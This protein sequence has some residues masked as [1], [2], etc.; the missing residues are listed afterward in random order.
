M[1]VPVPIDRE[2]LLARCLDDVEFT[3]QMLQ[4]FQDQSPATL[5]RLCESVNAGAWE[6]AKRHAHTLKGTAGNLSAAALQAAAAR[7]EKLV[8]AGQSADLDAAVLDLTNQFNL[9]LQSAIAISASMKYQ[10]R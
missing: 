4:I 5:T 8:E 3:R 6:D 1:S 10:K 9:C 2:K 7:V